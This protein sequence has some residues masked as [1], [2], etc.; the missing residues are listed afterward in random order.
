MRGI[1][2]G[3]SFFICK[4]EIITL[5]SQGNPSPACLPAPCLWAT[6]VLRGHTH[7]TGLQL[8][9]PTQMAGTW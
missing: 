5:T 1:S 4:V 8:S 9:G 2:L 7:H 6:S 3:F